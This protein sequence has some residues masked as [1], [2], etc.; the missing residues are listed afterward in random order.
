MKRERE[1]MS[2]KKRSKKQNR[3]RGRDRRRRKRGMNPLYVVIPV[4]LVV[5][6]VG[7]ALLASPEIFASPD[8]SLQLPGWI[9]RKGSKVQRAYTQA[10]AHRDELRY[11]PCYCGCGN[12]GH[13]AVADCHIAYVA[14]DGSI[15]FEEHAST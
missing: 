1:D 11:I 8:D 9:V 13:S 14:I 15:T 4:A 2:S 12:M 10:V 3:T 6:M 5:V 7:G